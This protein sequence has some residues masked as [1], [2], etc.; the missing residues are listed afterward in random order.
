M[1]VTETSRTSWFSRIKQ[2]FGGILFG[3]IIFILSFVLIWYNEGRAVK[4]AKGLKEG[5]AVVV[6]VPSD[7]ILA[8]NNDKL[9]HF[10]GK[11]VAT[12]SIQDP[13]L[14]IKIWGLK[15]Q[16]RVEIYQWREKS[17]TETDNKVGGAQETT[18]TY[19]YEKVWS[20]ALINSSN[21]KEAGH[22]NP[23]VK[24]VDDYAQQASISIGAFPLSQDLVSKIGSYEKLSPL[25]LNDSLLAELKY[26]INS[27]RNDPY[28]FSSI[29]HSE[30]ENQLYFGKSSM[31]APEIGDVRILY[32][33]IPSGEYSII[34]QQVQ[35]QLMAHQ[36]SH[37]TQILLLKK[38]LHSADV[39]FEQ[40]H[41]QNKIVTWL[42]RAAGFFLMFL[43]LTMIL[44]PLVVLASVLPFLGR[45]L[46]FGTRL[47]AGIIAAV[48]SFITIAIA[49]IF[50]R[51]I[52]GISLL[53]VALGIFMYFYMKGKDRDLPEEVRN[54]YLK[55]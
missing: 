36:T 27:G 18:T 48:L 29:R 23:Q 21:F 51:P 26:K 50:Y 2:S 52:L 12:D 3:F 30:T 41:R 5:E 16:R 55:K 40:A 7:T 22:E 31:S 10:S 35:S 4:T 14:G 19:T 34:A 33:Y 39:M 46:N 37:G 17:Q 13:L 32:R 20:S 8:S 54:N 45:L 11:A 28:S 42:L 38:G 1:S 47:F 53:V 49:W 15:L 6:S 44:R 43:G 9:I 24:L 25:N